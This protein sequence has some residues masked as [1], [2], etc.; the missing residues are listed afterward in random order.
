MLLLLK[1]SFLRKISPLVN[2]SFWFLFWMMKESKIALFPPDDF[3]VWVVE[4]SCDVPHGGILITCCCK[5]RV[6]KWML[7][8][9]SR[10]TAVTAVLNELHR[11]PPECLPDD[12]C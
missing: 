4:L 2:C 1:N 3:S 7:H 5:G 6:Q 8:R 9:C 10:D 12:T 11:T